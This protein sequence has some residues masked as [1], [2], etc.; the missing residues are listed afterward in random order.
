MRDRQQKEVN[1]LPIRFAFSQEQFHEVMKEWGLRPKM[2]LEKIARIPFG[3]FIQKKDAPLIRG[4]F[5][6]HHRELQAAIDAGPT[7]EGFIKDMFLYKLENHE[8][9]Y[10]GTAEDTLDSLGLSFED[11]AA[12]PRLAR[13]LDL[14]ERDFET[15]RGDEYVVEK[16]NWR[17]TPYPWLRPTPLSRNTTGTTAQ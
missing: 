12:D 11:V 1:A 7:G 6:R 8:Y 15:A 13:G 3:G 10:T 2:D 4:T 16:G 9:S 14:A 5:A 17:F